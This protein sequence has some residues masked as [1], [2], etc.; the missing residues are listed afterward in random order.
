MFYFYSSFYGVYIYSFDDHHHH[1]FHHQHINHSQ[2]S[3]IN[4]AGI[5]TTSSES[6][7]TNTTTS[8][9]TV[10]SSDDSITP[11]RRRRERDARNNAF[12]KQQSDYNLRGQ[13]ASICSCSSAD[14][15]GST[16]SSSSSGASS[17]YSL[18]SNEEKSPLI[19][20]IKLV[21]P[22]L[23]D[24]NGKSLSNHIING[25]G[26]DCGTMIEEELN[27]RNREF[28]KWDSN[29]RLSDSAY[30]NGTGGGNR[31]AS[32][33]LTVREMMIIFISFFFFFISSFHCYKKKKHF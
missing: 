28:S 30:V 4:G 26:N 17:A 23:V 16:S 2:N 10:L 29:H 12:I 24:E 21:P 8:S 32:L 20:T 15:Y 13:R 5:T 3:D 25:S 27:K 9:K 18:G 6:T 7:P 31:V 1:H 14:S 33:N 22:T 11:V 19:E